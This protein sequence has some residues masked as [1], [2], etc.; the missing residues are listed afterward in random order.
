MIF[1][2]TIIIIIF[3][4]T[5]L[6][7]AK[8]LLVMEMVNKYLNKSFVHNYLLVQMI[9]FLNVLGWNFIDD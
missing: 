1:T 6:L 7:R 9:M 3:L 4:I 2:L 5:V 8:L